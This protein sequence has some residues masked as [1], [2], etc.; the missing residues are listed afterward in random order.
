VVAVV[1]SVRARERERERERGGGEEE[2]REMRARE[3]YETKRRT[4]V[5]AHRPGYRFL[6]LRAISPVI[7]RAN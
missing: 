3:K 6:I 5:N 2:G 1:K 7:T 4:R